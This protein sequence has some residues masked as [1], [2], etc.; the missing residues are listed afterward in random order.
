MLGSAMR[1]ISLIP[2]A[3]EI[4]YLLGLQENL[5]ARS[6][7]S[8]FPEDA[9][10]KTIISSPTIG[11]NLSSLEI[12][13]AVRESVHS[14][15]SL[16]HLDQKLLADLRP[17][18]ILTQELCKVCAP[19]FTEVKQAAKILAR[20]TTI[21]SLEPESIE[22]M[23]ENIMTVGEHTGRQRKAEEAVAGFR[24]ILGEVEAKTKDVL[25]PSVVMIEWMEPIMIAGHWVPEMV[26]KA[27]GRILLSKPHQKSREASWQE[28]LDANPDILILA[29]CGFDMHRTKKEIG[30]FEEKKGWSELK[31]VRNQ[32]V[33]LVDGD[34]YL[35]RS[36][37]RLVQGTQILA[38]IFHPT[39]FG[40]PS[41]DEAENHVQQQRR[42]PT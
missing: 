14:G 1:I 31:A 9:L 7:D 33:Y 19:N 25:R 16:F 15:R 26:E 37:P 11:E 24:E 22:D 5:V 8:N 34:A 28:I 39:I 20:E 6:H 36:G 12:D 41:L 18:L 21:L 40:P 4:V 2:S 13:N 42:A 27:G 35:T 38:K 32:T 10:A 3:T 17:S 23:F 30:V 29:P